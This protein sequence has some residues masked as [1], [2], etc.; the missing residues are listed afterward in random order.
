MGLFSKKKEKQVDISAKCKEIYQEINKIV[1][2]ANIEGDI[3]IRLS[4]LQLAN[5]KY[6]DILTLIDQGANF[7]RGHF[8]ALKK[9]IEREIE[10]YNGL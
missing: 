5:T 7:D 10:L 3:Q 9:N 6:Q 1:Q 8:E 2:S 4:L